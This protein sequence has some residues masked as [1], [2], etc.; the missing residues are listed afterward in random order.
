[1]SGSK[2]TETDPLP[3]DTQIGGRFAAAAL[4]WQVKVRRCVV[5]TGQAIVV[6]A[7]VAEDRFWCWRTDDC[8]TPRLIWL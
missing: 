2:I 4:L 1:M 5:A 7:T 3:S 8:A 6:D